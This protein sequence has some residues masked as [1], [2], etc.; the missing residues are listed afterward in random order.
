M[1]I[2]FILLFISIHLLFCKTI[3]TT[4]LSNYEDIVLTNLTGIFTP[5]FDNKIIKGNLN[6]TFTA[7]KSGKEILLD[8]RYLK[9]ISISKDGESIQFKYGEPDPLYGPPLVIPC[10]YIEDEIVEIIIEYET[11]KNGT[12]AQFLNKNQTEGKKY[13]FLLSLSEMTFGRELLPSQDT[14]SVK[15]PF[16]LGMKV[17]NPIRGMIS[18]LFQ[19]KIINEE[20]NTTTYYYNQSIPV[21]NYLIALAAGNIEERVISDNVSVF[22]EPELLNKSAN[23]LDEM[24]NVLAIA[25]ELNGGYEW[26]KY[27]ILILP[28]S[29]PY[30]AMENPCLTFASSCLINGDK[31]LFDIFVHEL[32]HSWSGNLVTNSNWRDFWLNE[33]ITKYRQRQIVA[34]W[35]GSE[36]Y[37]KMDAILGLYH[38]EEALDYLG[39]DSNATCLRPN[40]DNIN[41]DDIYSDIPYEKGYNFM[42][43]VEKNVGREIMDAF[44]LNY[45]QEF[46]YKSVD[47]FDFK[48]YFEQ[49]CR[50]NGVSEENLTNIDWITWIY[51]AGPCPVPNDLNN[52]YL[53]QVEKELDKFI[54]GE[55]DDE[56]ANTFTS[57]MHTSKTVF[58]LKL[59]HRDEMLTEEQHKFLTE[60]LE[61]YHNQNFLVT[62]YYFRLIL[63]LTDKFYEHEEESLIEY[64]KSYGVTDFMYGIYELFY[65]RDE[66]AAVKTLEESSSF[67]HSIMLNK[68]KNDIENAK[69]N[70][71]I[72]TLELETTSEEQ[73]LILPENPKFNIISEEYKETLGNIEILDGIE[74][75]TGEK[76]INLVCYLND[77]NKYCQFKNENIDEGKYNIEVKERIQKKN[78]AIKKQTG[79]KKLQ[80][81]NSDKE[82]KIDEGKTQK[83]Y[84]I[85]YY[86][87]PKEII[88]IAFL[89]AP[90]GIHVYN[91]NKEL[92]CKINE[93]NLECEITK[94]IL[95]IDEAKPKE[96]KKYELNIMDAC[97]YLKYI[98]N[99]SV[100]EDENKGGEGDG[101][102]DESNYTWVYILVGVV[103]LIIIVV[104]VFFIIKAVKGKKNIEIEDGE[105]E[106]LAKYS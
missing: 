77:A 84:E 7:L 103:G 97:N 6:Y 86:T 61:L 59:E 73:C 79:K 72:M 63:G 15:F 18:G 99:V 85:N 89:Q 30:S 19:G 2:K 24:P 65:R 70:F 69:K 54:K 29:F 105:T 26:G 42:L 76:V 14:P 101:K 82:L 35:K 41:P 49:F 13:P 75:G 98:I 56:L 104:A 62:T 102:G 46:K 53:T 68:A 52:T 8:A 5:D 20:E 4:T 57:W 100:K 83:Y 16:Y 36:D 71:P 17:D 40:L 50:D 43:Y 64:L 22:S 67:Y 9:I 93:L 90:K 38:I 92:E 66:E 34:K 60:R 96:Y 45:F 39:R 47:L 21:P 23:E 31:S 87:K 91:D 80:I 58:F 78:Y 10:E 12:A 55:L 25:S 51:G 3:D 44:F 48:N 106:L 1:D 32:T 94:E 11:T 27:N 95:P 37:P 33:G 81:F 28:A 74:L 88:K